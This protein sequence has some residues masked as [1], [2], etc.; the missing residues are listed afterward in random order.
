MQT[1]GAFT[2]TISF[3]TSGAHLTCDPHLTCDSLVVTKAEL[4]QSLKKVYRKV[5][6]DDGS[7]DQSGC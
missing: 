6:S 7:G 2:L 3:S 5:H 4:F 1:W